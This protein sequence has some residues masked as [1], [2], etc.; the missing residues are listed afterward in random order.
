M[1]S[2]R[3]SRVSNN[4]RLNAVFNGDTSTCDFVQDRVG[5]ADGEAA[6][7][8]RDGAAGLGGGVAA[9][10]EAGTGTGV[11]PPLTAGSRRSVWSRTC[12][13]K[14]RSLAEDVGVSVLEQV[15]A[16]RRAVQEE[17]G[18]GV[19]LQR[20]VAGDPGVP[21]EDERGSVPEC[22][23][24]LPLGHPHLPAAAGK[25]EVVWPVGGLEG[26]S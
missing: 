6:L 1:N 21:V 16:R 13:S 3:R 20:V 7:H 14:Q 17:A 22:V 2:G 5:G 12:Q 4:R 10:P 11:I 25:Q 15:E 8:L 18:L 26:D 24:V 19:G 9:G 23:T